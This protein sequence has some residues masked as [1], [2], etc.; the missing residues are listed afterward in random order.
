[1]A[2]SL[3]PFGTRF[4]L[5]DEIRKEMDNMLNRRLLRDDG[6]SSS[7]ESA[8]IPRINLSEDDKHFEVAV[9][10]PDM[11]R[12][13][14]EIELRN[15]EL[16]ISG[17]RKTEHEEKGKTWHHV[18]RHYG[19]FRRVIHMGEHVDAENVDA[20]YADGVLRVTVPKAAT[21]QTKRIK[22]K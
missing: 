2:T 7:K 8:W 11:K 20:S 9:D 14:F 1:M 3:V 17:H 12:E 6:G 22:V 4:G 13:D 19:Q 5:F 21:E 10:V 16:S 18:E 15:G